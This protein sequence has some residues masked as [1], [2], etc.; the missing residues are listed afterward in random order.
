MLDLLLF[1]GLCLGLMI[2]SYYHSYQVQE[3]YLDKVHALTERAQE[4]QRKW[5]TLKQEYAKL[6][7]QIYVYSLE[8]HGKERTKLAQ[9][10]FDLASRPRKTTS[11]YEA[12]DVC[13]ELDPWMSPAFN[14][15]Q[16]GAQLKEKCDV[17]R[18]GGV[19]SGFHPITGLPWT[20]LFVTIRDLRALT[21]L[22]D[23]PWIHHIRLTNM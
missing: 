14:M 23:V 17:T 6:H 21:K 15:D 20:H 11:K 16:D 13:L 4:W 1:A 2:Y 12:V 7:R 10:L 9:S 19:F 8:I 3:N 22:I 18:L 5:E